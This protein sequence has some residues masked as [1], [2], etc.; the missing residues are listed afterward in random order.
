VAQQHA[1]VSLLNATLNV[2]LET[3]QAVIIVA[4]SPAHKEDINIVQA[5]KAVAQI[6][7]GTHALV[8]AVLV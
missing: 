4:Q 8:E 6:A 2:V 3:Q 1:L 7:L 5:Q